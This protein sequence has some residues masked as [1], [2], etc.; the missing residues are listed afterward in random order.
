MANNNNVYLKEKDLPVKYTR[1]FCHLNW[2]ITPGKS[3]NVPEVPELTVT[4]QNPAPGALSISTNRAQ[5]I[6]TRWFL[7]QTFNFFSSIISSPIHS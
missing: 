2:G 6:S 3:V 7:K 5:L 4:S 1:K